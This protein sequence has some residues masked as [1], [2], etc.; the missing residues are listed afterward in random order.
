MFFGLLTCVLFSAVS[1]AQT[2]EES[3]ALLPAADVVNQKKEVAQAIELK[4]FTAYKL[5]PWY[6]FNQVDFTDDGKY[7]D[8]KAGDG[9]YTSR[10]A[11]VNPKHRFP[12]HAIVDERFTKMEALNSWITTNRPGIGIGIRCKFRWVTTGT[13]WFGNSCAGGCIE[14]YDCELDISIGINRKK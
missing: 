11:S 14:V 6:S 12:N 8:L 13:S 7:N 9:I 5:L 1:F 3:V 2:F 4:S 10:Y